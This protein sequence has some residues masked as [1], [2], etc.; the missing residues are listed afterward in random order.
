M[1]KDDFPY[2]TPDLPD[3]IDYKLIENESELFIT[4]MRTRRSPKA[5]LK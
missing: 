3:E 2:K 5:T 1:S 4:Q